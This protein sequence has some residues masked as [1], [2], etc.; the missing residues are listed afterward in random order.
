ML[1]NLVV[2]IVFGALVGWVASLIMGTNSEQGGI[3]NIV[4]GILGAIVGGFIARQLWGGDVTGFNMTS[5][6]VAL[7]GALLL[8]G[9]LKVFRGNRV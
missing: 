1:F 8:I 2:W 6:L 4:I 5:F 9:V 3:S 7:G